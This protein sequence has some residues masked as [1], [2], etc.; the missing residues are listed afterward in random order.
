M[1]E[2]HAVMDFI[3]LQGG[4]RNAP[5]HDLLNCQEKL[6]TEHELNWPSI[7]DRAARAEALAIIN[8]EL[9]RRHIQGD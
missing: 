7:E 1:S 2:K 5:I 6:M 8:G 3:H 4:L 9:L